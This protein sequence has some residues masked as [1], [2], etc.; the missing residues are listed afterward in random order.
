MKFFP[1]L[2]LALCAGTALASS[3]Q[4]GEI[5]YRSQH[6]GDW[7]CAS[8]HTDNPMTVGSHAVTK[9]TIQPIAPAANPER[10]TRPE[11]VEKWFKRNCN[12]V[13]KRACTPQEKADFL[14]YLLTFK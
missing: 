6:G 10:F 11:K 14:A 5:F 12:D 3:A 7:S 2:L 4:R 8:C 9:K 13:L 1:L